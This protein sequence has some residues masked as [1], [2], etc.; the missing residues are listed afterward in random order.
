MLE[1]ECDLLIPAALE[2][3]I[4]A[5]NAP[6]IKAKLIAEAANGPVTPA[7][8]DLLTKRGVVI[9]PDLLCNA[10]GKQ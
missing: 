7:A 1:Y 3:Q 10:G 5:I 4:N 2:Q 8:H 6:Q 9:I